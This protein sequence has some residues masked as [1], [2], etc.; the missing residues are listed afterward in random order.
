MKMGQMYLPTVEEYFSVE[1]THNLYIALK[2]NTLPKNFPVDLSISNIVFSLV[3]KHRT[4]RCS[5]SCFLDPLMT[6]F[7]IIVPQYYNCYINVSPIIWLLF[8]PIEQLYS[9]NQ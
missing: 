4:D 9:N 6:C 8:F 2:N 1:V 3:F 7:Q 5:V